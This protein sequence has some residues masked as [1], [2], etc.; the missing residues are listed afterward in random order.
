MEARSIIKEAVELLLESYRDHAA[1]PS[2]RTD[3]LVSDNHKPTVEIVFKDPKKAS[4]DEL[5]DRF[6]AI[7]SR[8]EEDDPG[9]LA[10]RVDADV[11]DPLVQG[12]EDSRF[13]PS[14]VED[15][16]VR[17]THESLVVD[18]FGLVARASEFGDNLRREVLVDLE[19]HASTKGR[20][21]SSW[22]S[23][24]AYAMAASMCS[25]FREG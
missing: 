8:S 12:Q 25:G 9:I 18:R 19:P 21:L 14:P 1:L 24:A 6:P 23:S 4:A 20:R 13:T 10:R 11:T 5:E 15:D 22:A 2:S 16:R 3:T 7:G 17:S